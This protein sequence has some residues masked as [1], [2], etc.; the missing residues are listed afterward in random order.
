MNHIQAAPD[1]NHEP[2]ITQ[3]T[4]KVRASGSHGGQRNKHQ[5]HFNISAQTTLFGFSVLK[6][7]Q[8]KSNSA[9]QLSN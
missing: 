4:L 8:I 6:I 3:Y 5:C 7:N 2:M 9:I 1:H